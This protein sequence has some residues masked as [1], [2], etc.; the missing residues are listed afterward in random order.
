MLAASVGAPLFP[1]I[2]AEGRLAIPKPAP[3]DA[4]M[5]FEKEPICLSTKECTIGARREDNEL[6]ILSENKDSPPSF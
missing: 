2:T 5:A 6:L 3:T 1:Q 4:P